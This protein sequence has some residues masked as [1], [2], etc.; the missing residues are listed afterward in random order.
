M[1]IDLDSV[2]NGGSNDITF[3]MFQETHHLLILQKHIVVINNDNFLIK[4]HI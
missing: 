3:T 4:T 1:N 2:P